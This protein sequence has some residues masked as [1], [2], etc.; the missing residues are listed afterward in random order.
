MVRWATCAASDARVNGPNHS[1]RAPD[2]LPGF[3][4]SLRV[5][6]G[7]QDGEDENTKT[8]LPRSGSDAVIPVSA[9]R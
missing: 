4:R 2:S 8:E 9:A 7:G 1:L 3:R 6:A 5:R